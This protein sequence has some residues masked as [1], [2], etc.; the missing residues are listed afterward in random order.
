MAITENT[1]FVR[2]KNMSKKKVELEVGENLI[3]DLEV[4]TDTIQR[5]SLNDE[6]TIVRLGDSFVIHLF[7][8]QTSSELAK[9]KR[10][11]YNGLVE[12]LYGPARKK[13]TDG[14]LKR[15]D[16]SYKQFADGNLRIILQRALQHFE[17]PKQEALA[18]DK[19]AAWLR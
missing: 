1:Y 18:S 16:R 14:L 5:L 2:R 15:G 13:V 9:Q 19:L 8:R 4:L 3:E 11:A 10:Y 7:K 6:Q 12:F 17:L